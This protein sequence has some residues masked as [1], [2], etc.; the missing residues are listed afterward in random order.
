[1]NKDSAFMRAIRTFVQAMVGF[2]VGLVMVVW[3]VAGVPEA[4]HAYIVGHALQLMLTI[5]IPAGVAS[6]VWNFFRKNVP[7]F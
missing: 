5:G 2:I 1:M 6:F 7:N 3:H 4:V